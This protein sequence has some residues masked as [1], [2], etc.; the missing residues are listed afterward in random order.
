MSDEDMP[1]SSQLAPYVIGGPW[2][3][4]GD[5][6]QWD[7]RTKETVKTAVAIYKRWRTADLTARV[8]APETTAP[9]AGVATAPLADGSALAAFVIR[10]EDVGR[11]IRWMPRLA[12]ATSAT[13][14]DEWTGATTSLD[15]ASLSAGILLDTTRAGGL[16]LSV[17]PAGD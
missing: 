13:L 2:I 11:E 8:V 9:V 1:L 17:M 4:M 3:F 6:P 14:T 16:V 5:L 12:N 15:A 7:S 10:D